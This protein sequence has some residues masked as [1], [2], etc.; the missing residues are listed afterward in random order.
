M[1]MHPLLQQGGTDFCINARCARPV[2]P[3]S[4]PQQQQPPYSLMRERMTGSPILSCFIVSRSSGKMRRG[5]RSQRRGLLTTTGPPAALSFAA[6]AALS[7]T[8]DRLANTAVV[9]ASRGTPECS[10]RG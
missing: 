3:L 8:A 6:T 5:T 10:G 9:M 1:M 2:Q 4:T 7:E